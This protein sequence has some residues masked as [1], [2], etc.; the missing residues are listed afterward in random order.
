MPGQFLLPV[1]VAARL[2]QGWE[3]LDPDFRVQGPDQ[4][5]VETPLGQAQGVL[6]LFALPFGDG[7]GGLDFKQGGLALAAGLVFLLE[8]LDVLLAAADDLVR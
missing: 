2:G 6:V 4:Y 1:G 7:E 5:P 8:Q 3:G